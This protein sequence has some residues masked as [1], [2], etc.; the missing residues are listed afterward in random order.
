M[1]EEE[2]ESDEAVV[3]QEPSRKKKKTASVVRRQ[4]R[5]ATLSTGSWKTEAD[6]DQPPPAIWFTPNRNEGFQL[7]CAGQKWSP[8]DLFLLFFSMR[9]IGIIVANTNA[10]AKHLGTK[11]KSLKWFPLTATEFLAFLSIIFFMGMVEVPVMRDYWNNDNFF[12]QDF[13]RN[14]GMSHHRFQNIL[15]ALHVCDLEEDAA[16]E[17][18]KGQS[19]L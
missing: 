3:N 10:Y 19:E 2:S 7:P 15:A 17:R 16:N 13:I 14:S 1:V 6:V 4:S 12:G 11:L 9:S 18:K 5:P 8:A